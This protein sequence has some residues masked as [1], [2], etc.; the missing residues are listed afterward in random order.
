MTIINMFLKD[1]LVPSS[2]LFSLVFSVLF[3]PITA[4]A[5]LQ[6]TAIDECVLEHLVSSKLDSAARLITRSCEENFHKPNFLTERR[7]QYNACLLRH[8]KGVESE[9]AVH[10][11][12]QVCGKKHL[13][14][15]APTRP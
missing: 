14:F 3:F 5:D 8:L 2:L 9:F 10:K 15:G 6:Q 4:N 11:I 1:A 7:K 13:R 12:L